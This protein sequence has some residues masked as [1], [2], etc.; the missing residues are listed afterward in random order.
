VVG[1]GYPTGY[2]GLPVNSQ[3]PQFH[4]DHAYSVLQ[5][6]V[7][8]MDGLP[9]RP[10]KKK[11]Y[12]KSITFAALVTAVA[13]VVGFSAPVANLPTDIIQIQAEPMLPN[14]EPSALPEPISDDELGVALWVAESVALEV[15]DYIEPDQLNDAIAAASLILESGN[16]NAEEI[17]A[18]TEALNFYSTDARSQARVVEVERIAERARGAVANDELSLGG[19][20]KEDVLY[21]LEILGASDIGVVY[22]SPPCGL[23]S[24]AAC[25]SSID[26]TFMTIDDQILDIWTDAEVFNTVAHELAHTIH[27]RSGYERVNALPGVV[28][29]FGADPEHLAD[30]MAEDITGVVFSTYGNECSRAQLEIARSVWNLPFW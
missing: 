26:P 25:V 17:T 20:R 5:Q 4:A 19:D 10:R 1:N 29:E 24:A 2:D 11:T 6:D 13:F 8:P 23:S 9:R 12:R 16:A 15:S 22:D 14:G 18:A 28:E 27:F 3:Q 30:C 21:M 7:P